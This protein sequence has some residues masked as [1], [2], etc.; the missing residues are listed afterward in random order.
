MVILSWPS[1]PAF[2]RFEKSE[3]QRSP[4]EE[5][6]AEQG[7][8]GSGGNMPFLLENNNNAATTQCNVR[9]HVEFLRLNKRKRDLGRDTS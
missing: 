4:K 2:L 9:P 7:F 3:K 8:L 1:W 6:I 5:I